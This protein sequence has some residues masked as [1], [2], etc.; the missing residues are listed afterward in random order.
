[1]KLL[2]STP[3]RKVSISL[4]TFWDAPKSAGRTTYG[5]SWASVPA[6]MTTTTV[7]LADVPDAIRVDRSTALD[8]FA[9]HCPQAY[10][11]KPSFKRE[12]DRLANQLRR[13]GSLTLGCWCVPERCCYGTMSAPKTGWCSSATS[14]TTT[15][16]LPRR[17]LARPDFGRCFSQVKCLVLILYDKTIHRR[18]LRGLRHSLVCFAVVQGRDIP[19]LRPAHCCPNAVL[20]LTEASRGQAGHT[21]HFRCRVDHDARRPQILCGQMHCNARRRLRHH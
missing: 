13:D 7:N 4:N 14:P 19:S 18:L 9:H 10:A 3:G 2:A 6:A 21:L 1:M 5:K 11:R 12:I 17:K 8:A 15:R 20:K 16:S